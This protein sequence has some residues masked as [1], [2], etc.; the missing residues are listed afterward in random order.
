MRKNGV[1]MRK[2]GVIM[3]KNGVRMRKNGVRMEYEWSTNGVRMKGRR[4]GWRGIYDGTRQ[5]RIFCT[6]K[7]PQRHTI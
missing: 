1:R 2:N 3:R 7:D 5:G 6:C 4:C